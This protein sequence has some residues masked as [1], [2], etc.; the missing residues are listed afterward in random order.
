M[1]GTIA[2]LDS[3]TY[4]TLTEND[5][6]VEWNP[7]YRSD[8]QETVKLAVGNTTYITLEM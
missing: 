8:G 6:S 5:P 1:L 2:L 4:V 3:G 7:F